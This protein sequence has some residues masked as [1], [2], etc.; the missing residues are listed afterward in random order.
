MFVRGVYTSDTIYEPDTLPKALQYFIPQPAKSDRQ[1][2]TPWESLYEWQWFPEQPSHIEEASN[3]PAALNTS[4]LS[5]SS[6]NHSIDS[7]TYEDRGKRH[8]S[9]RSILN[10]SFDENSFSDANLGDSLSDDREE[11]DDQVARRPSIPDNIFQVLEAHGKGA[12]KIMEHLVQSQPRKQVHSEGASLNTSFRMAHDVSLSSNTLQKANEVLKSIGLE[13]QSLPLADEFTTFPHCSSEDD[14]LPSISGLE[15]DPPMG[16]STSPK[17]TTWPDPVM[18]LHRVIGYTGTYSKCL[19]WTTDGTACV[20]PSVS[21]IVTLQLPRSRSSDSASPEKGLPD[22]LPDFLK[23]PEPQ[24]SGSTEED[25]TFVEEDLND[26]TKPTSLSPSPFGLSEPTVESS[27]R[28]FFGHTEPITC[29][30]FNSNSTLLASSQEGKNPGVRLWDFASGTCVAIMSGHVSKVS[31][32]N[33]SINDRHFCSVGLDE[34]YRTQLMIWDISTIHLSSGNNIPSRHNIPSTKKKPRVLSSQGKPLGNT[35]STTGHPKLIARQTCEFPISTIAFSPYES[36]RLV[37]CGRENIRFWRMK[38]GHLPGCPVILNEYSR[39]T[40]FTDLAFDQLYGTT[41]T[42]HPQ[43][44]AAK[45]VLERPVYVASNHGTLFLVN[46]DTLELTC[47]YRLHDGPIHALAVNEGFCVTGSEDTILRVWPLDFSEYYLEASHDDAIKSVSVSRDGLSVLVGSTGGSVG[48]LSLATQEYRSVSRS[49][50]DV[51]SCLAVDP[52]RD[53]VASASVDGSL[54]VWTLSSL[55]S[56]TTSGR[57]TTCDVVRQSVEFQVRDDVVTAMTYHPTRRVLAVGFASGATRIFDILTTSVVEEYQQHQGDVASVVYTS[58]GSKLLSSGS[59]DHQLC[60]YDVHR[61]YQ[62][63]K[64]IPC[65]FTNHNATL[66]CSPDDRLV[67]Y[68]VSDNDDES[69]SSF[70]SSS[71]RCQ[72]LDL[73]T[74]AP[75]RVLELGRKSSSSNNPHQVQQIHF[76]HT[77][78]HVVAIFDSHRVVWCDVESGKITRSANLTGQRGA[79]GTFCLSPNGRYLAT[80]DSDYSIKVWDVESVGR[81]RTQTFIGHSGPISSLAFSGDGKRVLSTGEGNAIFV[82][83]FHGDTTTP[84]LPQVGTNDANH[85]SLSSVSSICEHHSEDEQASDWT[86]DFDTQ[87]EI[88]L[89]SDQDH[90]DESQ[91]RRPLLNTSSHLTNTTTTSPPFSPVDDDAPTLTTLPVSTKTRGHLALAQVKGLNVECPVQWIPRLATFVYAVNDTVV[92]ENLETDTQS[93]LGASSSRI[94]RLQ[95]HHGSRYV[96]SIDTN[97]LVIVWDLLHDHDHP[98][99][100][101]LSI[102]LNPREDLPM[103]QHMDDTHST[104]WIWCSSTH[105]SSER[106]EEDDHPH[107]HSMTTVIECDVSTGKSRRQSL[108]HLDLP[109]DI[110]ALCFPTCCLLNESSI[111]TCSRPAK[112]LCVLSKNNH[113]ERDYYEVTKCLDLPPRVSTLEIERLVMT[114]EKLVLMLDDRGAIWMYDIIHETSPRVLGNV[115]GNNNNNVTQDVCPIVDLQWLRSSA[116]SQHLL[117]TTANRGLI[118]FSLPLLTPDDEEESNCPRRAVLDVQTITQGGRL[119]RKKVYPFDGQLSGTASSPGQS[120]VVVTTTPGSIWTLD[121][122][123]QVARVYCSDCRVTVDTIEHV[124][125]CVTRSSSSSSLGGLVVTID[126][127]A[128]RVWK[129]STLEHLVSYRVSNETSPTCLSPVHETSSGVFAVAVGYSDGSLRVFDLEQCRLACQCFPFSNETESSLGL[130]SL[131]KALFIQHTL[132]V[133]NARGQTVVVMNVESSLHQSS[134]LSRQRSAVSPHEAKPRELLVKGLTLAQEESK[135]ENVDIL[136]LESATKALPETF[137]VISSTVGHNP[138]IHICR[139]GAR[140]ARDACAIEAW[141]VRVGKRGQVSAVFSPTNEALVIYTTM[142]KNHRTPCLEIRNFHNRQVQYRLGLTCMP[143]S[144]RI[145]DL[146]KLP[147]TLEAEANELSTSVENEEKEHTTYLFCSDDDSK[148]FL[149]H[150]QTHEMIDVRLE[151]DASSC[152]KVKGETNPRTNDDAMMQW[153]SCS[154]D[155][156]MIGLSRGKLCRFNLSIVERHEAED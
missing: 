123:T 98:E 27:Q 129:S 78:D 91:P 133:A 53:E 57:S 83:K 155:G 92:V 101:S 85:G 64:M 106:H 1:V 124:E 127:Q 153:K 45:T 66:V 6:M 2:Q 40:T 70:K 140:D 87:D 20:Y 24:V 15:L 100:V 62:P 76:S 8:F 35:M 149:F 4:V 108:T 55:S 122:Q 46:Y 88:H 81:H 5:Q 94:C 17:S 141:T 21:T 118:V 37:S 69:S 154:V 84:S 63:V 50:T 47:V 146:K 38:K 128:I 120:L 68:L 82:W 11:K 13:D 102:Q 39:N 104:L 42:H 12:G 134:A 60:V 33:F 72:L 7:T 51:V 52:S 90:D 99:V 150:P 29:L 71:S 117:V 67:G 23:S 3:D 93:R 61:G 109:H 73:E 116:S 86:Q 32:L 139:T 115:W 136:A 148:T 145:L 41:T 112:Y 135:S 56:M 31:N 89:S 156:G 65:A 34:H 54:R 49:H 107:P 125:C 126:P 80:A 77:G 121:V 25:L 114:D 97:A 131:T 147:E 43:Q 9:Q 144:I 95:H 152:Q 138:K 48:V 18:H 113:P 30:A 14:A 44:R 26:W 16:S 142:T 119:G 143:R 28:F 103:F 105:S 111:I 74:L 75:Y 151:E 58:D 19:L 36:N 96:V 59:V 130:V 132:V 79:F 137:L 110:Q 10:E 22:H